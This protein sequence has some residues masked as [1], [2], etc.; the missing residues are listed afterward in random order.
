[1]QQLS[2]GGDLV[3]REYREFKKKMIQAHFRSETQTISQ[4]TNNGQICVRS[5]ILKSAKSYVKAVRTCVSQRNCWFQ[6]YFQ[7]PQYFIP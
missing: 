5:S 1:M 7:K 4:T 6:K 3:Y 2:G